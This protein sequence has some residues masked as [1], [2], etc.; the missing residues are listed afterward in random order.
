[1]DPDSELALVDMAACPCWRRMNSCSNGCGRGRVPWRTRPIIHELQRVKEVLLMEREVGR[2][3]VFFKHSDILTDSDIPN[4]P[5][6]R[7]QGLMLVDL[8]NGDIVQLRQGS[9]YHMHSLRGPIIL[10]FCK[11]S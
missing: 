4:P 2:G 7:C 8:V 3:V 6:R 1:M 9:C 10:A 11:Q 5:W